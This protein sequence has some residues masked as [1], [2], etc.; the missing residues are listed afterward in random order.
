MDLD[1]AGDHLT[2]EGSQDPATLNLDPVE[3]AFRLGLGQMGFRQSH[4]MAP[5]RFHLGQ[6]AVL[7]QLLTG[8][9]LG[10]QGARQL[11][12]IGRA[13]KPDQQIPAMEGFAIPEGHLQHPAIDLAGEYRLILGAQMPRTEASAVES[14]ALA[15]ASTPPPDSL[16]T[17]PLTPASC[18]SSAANGGNSPLAT[19]AS[20]AALADWRRAATPGSRPAPRAH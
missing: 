10:R 19:L 14:A 12:L 18:I 8:R 13:V 7:R 20:S 2:I 3:L 9:L 6:L 1:L 5:H 11:G 4:G 15:P 16:P 17:A